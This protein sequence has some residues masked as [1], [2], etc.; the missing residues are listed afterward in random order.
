MASLRHR[1]KTAQTQAVV[2]AF[3]ARYGIQV[4][5]LLDRETREELVPGL[6][7]KRTQ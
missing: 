2:R 7:R 6:N 3:Q 4:S 1:R 5:G